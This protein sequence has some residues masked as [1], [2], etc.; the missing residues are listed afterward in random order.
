LKYQNRNSKGKSFVNKN[1]IKGCKIVKR[2]SVLVIVLISFLLFSKMIGTETVMAAATFN[3]GNQ[4]EKGEYEAGAVQPTAFN[5]TRQSPYVSSSDGNQ[6]WKYSTNGMVR[7]SP[8]IGADGTIYVGCDSPI[9]WAINADGSEKCRASNGGYDRSSPVIGKD[10]VIYDYPE[11]M[12]F[13]AFNEN[14]TYKWSSGMMAPG[15]G[16]SA[17]IGGDGTIY[18]GSG[19]SLC[20]IDGTTG[21]IKRSIVIGSDASMPSPAIGADGTIY[22]CSNNQLY[23]IKADGSQKWSFATGGTI[24]SSPAIGADGTIYVGSYDN[25]LYAINPDGTPKWFF[26]TGGHVQSSPAVGADG[27]IYVGSEDNNLYA[28]K[29][30]GTQKWF[31]TTTGQIHS[32]P[33]IGGEGT[34]YVGSDDHNL[35]AVNAD[36][37]PKWFFTT[38]G[39]VQSSPAIGADGT[40]YVGSDD[41]HLYAIGKALT[42]DTVGLTYG[43]VGRSYS[44]TEII[45]TGGNPAYTWSASGLPPGVVI[46]GSTGELT[47]TPTTVGTSTARITVTDENGVS[48]SE[49][50][51]LE[52]KP[53]VSGVV[54]DQN[55]MILATGGATGTLTATVNP[56]NAGN[57]TV[58]WSSQDNNVATV[59]NGLVT[60]VGVG[61]TNIAVTT[62]DGGYTTSC[63]ITVTPAAAAQ[64]ELTT[65]I[66]AP[67]VNGGQFG[68]Q[69]VMVLKDIYGNICT[70][71]NS[72]EVTVEKKD[73]GAWNLTGTLTKKA[74]NGVVTFTDLG[75]TNAVL[76]NNAQLSFTTAGLTAVTSSLVVMPA[77]PVSPT[78]ASG[79]NDTVN[80]SFAEVTAGDTVTITAAGDRQ[81]QSGAVI[82]DERYIPTTWTS[83]ESGKTG[84]FTLNG[85]IY[86]SSYST[87]TASNYTVTSNYKKQT[88][89][90][91]D[92]LDS[93][94]A[95]T[96]SK[97][98]NL[99]VNAYIPPYVPPY[100]PPQ[101][102]NETREIPVVIEDGEKNIDAGQLTATRSIDG[103]GIKKDSIAVE[104]T[105]TTE[106]M[107]KV[108]ETKKDTV[109]MI[110]TDISGNNADLVEV[111]VSKKAMA[112]FAE[113]KVNLGVETEKAKLKFSKETI[114]SVKDED[115]KLTIGEVKD[116]K[117]IEKTNVLLGQME[118]GAERIN[119]PITI[120]SNA[121]L[122][123]YKESLNATTTGG[124]VSASLKN[125]DIE[126]ITLPIK[127]SD[128]P[129]DKSKLQEFINSLAILVQHSDGENRLQKG[130]IEYDKDGNPIGVTIWVD[131]FS[132]FTLVN[133]NFDGKVNTNSK[134]QM[135]DKEWNIQFTKEVDPKTVTED[136][137]YVLDSKGSKVDVELKSSVKGV[138]IKPVQN[139]KLGETYD[140]YVTKNIHSKSGKLIKQPIKYD[141]TIG[142][143][144]LSNKK[145]GEYTNISQTK[146]WIIKFTQTIDIKAFDSKAIKVVDENCN[147]IEVESAIV[148]SHSI[149]VKPKNPYEKGKVYYLVVGGLKSEQGKELKE[150]AWIKFSVDE[151]L[152]ILDNV[153]K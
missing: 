118:E 125:A 95:V 122:G 51:S 132:T 60:S 141:F 75:E 66:L 106:I 32:S 145:M 85:G 41:G 48:I 40:I 47:G 138:T 83:T 9:V 38:Q 35:Y 21:A 126:E 56:A 84:N 128:L 88:W 151:S 82:G 77:P 18:V 27:T 148:D 87:S 24:L 152:G 90:G 17:A 110:V 64:M 143:I 123:A 79:I 140:L 102:Q 107:K 2:K 113:N 81:G 136:N 142:N 28:I 99:T 52:I 89:N 139:Y 26:T 124:A 105:K 10:G 14:G 46:N 98:I 74:V 16:S 1:E 94:P 33:I 134:K 109:D 62:V 103:N 72:T 45:A 131:K 12:Y 104:D 69:P 71:D 115:I 80:L 127:N 58:T 91:T 30:D 68:R 149:N 37:S 53:V 59:A 144:P 101:P 29:A 44:S 150:T 49:N 117:E 13:Q 22:M 93:D 67:T 153:V 65:D 31:F 146:E 92:W 133:T 111:Q 55:T 135:P 97:T 39:A 96:D 8:V 73:S 100:I 114:M 129:K 121:A 119:A 54:L 6:K 78:T 112:E 4:Y 36:G 63:A 50:L 25:K 11:S 147:E 108:L 43:T 19:N 15:G 120:E 61:N 34:V 23:A 130:T 7:S 70:G 86:T 20:I 137:I 42:I 116:A 5:W 76:V 57:K 3:Q